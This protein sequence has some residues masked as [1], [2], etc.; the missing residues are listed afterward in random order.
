MLNILHTTVT[1]HPNF[2]ILL[3]CSIPAVSREEDSV[4]PDQMA[5]DLDLQFFHK[6]LKRINPMSAQG[7]IDFTC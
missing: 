1:L 5:S 3:T 6:F 4:D 2:F 7:L